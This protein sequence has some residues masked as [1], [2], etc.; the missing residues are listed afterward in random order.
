MFSLFHHYLYNNNQI[1][2]I[3]G[4]YFNLHGLR[5][6]IFFKPKPKTKFFSFSFYFIRIPSPL[7]CQLLHQHL[8]KVLFFC[9]SF[10]FF[11]QQGNSIRLGINKL[12][13]KLAL[14]STRILSTIGGGC[15]NTTK[16]VV[17]IAPS[18]AIASAH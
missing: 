14:S 12:L 6:T 13:R 3:V 17:Q 18:L 4:L 8:I 5:W 15:K 16:E 2:I 10:F 9:F 7:T 1:I 11:G